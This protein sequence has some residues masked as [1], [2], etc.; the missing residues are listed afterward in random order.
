MTLT[1]HTTPIWNEWWI[2]FVS[3][4]NTVWM[5]HSVSKEF[6]DFTPHNENCREG[7]F[8]FWCVC[9]ILLKLFTQNS[10]WS[11][12]LLFSLVFFLF[13]ESYV[14]HHNAKTD[15]IQTVKLTVRVSSTNWISLRFWTVDLNDKL[16]HC[17]SNC[18]RFLCLQRKQ[19]CANQIKFITICNL[20]PS[21]SR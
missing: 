10:L 2:C 21:S 5:T 3:D 14:Y 6:F 1:Q 16:L 8:L 7:L 20:F 11:T 19:R 17:E 13:N 15:S 18:N 9:S 12:P 4:R